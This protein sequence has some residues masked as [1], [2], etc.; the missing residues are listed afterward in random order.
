MAKTR[1]QKKQILQK[2]EEK[3][4]KSKSIVF[5]NFESLGVKENEELR[6]NLRENNSEYLVVKKTLLN[7]ALKKNKIEG[8]DVKVIEGKASIALGYKDE[9]APAKTISEFQ[10]E[11]EDKITFMGG[12]LDGSVI[13]AEKVTNLAK[14]PSKEELYAKLVGSINAPISGFVNTLAGNL[15]NLVFTLKAIEEQKK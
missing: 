4:K 8:F 15:K 11:H 13:S 10:K 7:L 14:L 9:V 1:E 5:A 3:I 12:V 6:N 2:L